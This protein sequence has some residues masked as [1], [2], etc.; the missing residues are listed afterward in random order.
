MTG[1]TIDAIVVTFLV[2][3]AL[4]VTCMGVVTPGTRKRAI[5]F[6]GIFIPSDGMSLGK[7]TGNNMETAF[8][9]IVAVEAEVCRVHVDKGRPVR[10]M[11]VVAYGTVPHGS[12][13]MVHFFIFPEFLLV[14]MAKET[15]RL[16]WFHCCIFTF[17]GNNFVTTEACPRRNWFVLVGAV[18]LA[19]V[20]LITGRVFRFYRVHIVQSCFHTMTGSAGTFVGR[21]MEVVA[22]EAWRRLLV[23]LGKPGAE[24]DG[25]FASADGPRRVCGAYI[26]LVEAIDQRYAK[27]DYVV[28]PSFRDG[29]GKGCAVYKSFNGGGAAA[30]ERQHNA[31]LF[32]LN[33]TVVCR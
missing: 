20:A 29:F 9:V 22:L 2:K 5:R 13:T 3:Q 23:L 7:K 10:A 31:E 25:Q 8:L 18:I 27:T 33:K 4:A 16:L 32:V 21:H 1:L 15:D 24:I 26:N 12:G 6:K 19:L 28:V 14:A 17:P 11:R 30:L